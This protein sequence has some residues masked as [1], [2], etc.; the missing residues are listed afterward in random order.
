MGLK[1]CWNLAHFD[2]GTEEL[3]LKKVVIDNCHFVNVDYVDFGTTYLTFLKYIWNNKV[4][5]QVSVVFYVKQEVKLDFT[6]MPN[7]D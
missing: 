2:M 1:K 4:F 3:V 5:F 7:F 6:R